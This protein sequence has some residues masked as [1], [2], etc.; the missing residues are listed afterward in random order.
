METLTI[1]MPDNH[2]GRLKELALDFNV[3]M[4]ELIRLSIESLLLQPEISLQQA[5]DYVL[6]KNRDLYRRLA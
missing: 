3:T 1:T 6:D 4:E 2:I 5:M